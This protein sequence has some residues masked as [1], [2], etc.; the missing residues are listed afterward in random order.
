M[1]ALSGAQLTA[2]NLS[3]LNSEFLSA[4]KVILVIFAGIALLVAAFSI[5]STFGI[6]VAQ[7]TREAALLRALGAT[8][9]QVLRGVLAEALAVGVAGS[10]VGTAAGL[11]LAELLKG[12]F[13]RAGFALPAG[14]LDVTGGSLAVSLATGIVVTVAVSLVPAVRASRVAPLEA[15]RESAAEPADIP[16]RR[17]AAGLVLLVAG[18]AAVAAG[19]TGPGSRGPGIVALGALA[20][21]FG[22]VALGPSAAGPAIRLATRPLAAARGVA[23]T[24]AGRSASGHPRR[25]AAAATALMIGVAVVTLF[26]VYAASLRAGAVSGVANSFTG[27][28]AITPGGAGAGPGAAGYRW[29]WPA[30]WPG[31]RASPR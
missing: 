17:T 14:G 16:R 25:T 31:C 5:A 23:G 10:A 12:V 28:I 29:P 6:V 7:R 4:L 3:D 30:R 21:T 15:L 22:V 13:D 26:T 2:E 18:L 1:Q 8:R 9:G 11:G 19:L 27:D 20:V 24:L